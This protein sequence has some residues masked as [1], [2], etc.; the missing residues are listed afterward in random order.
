[1]NDKFATI[2][3]S[4][5]PVLIDFFATW[6]G[7]CQML[8]PILK[9]VKESL[10][11]IDATRVGMAPLDDVSNVEKEWLHPGQAVVDTV[12]HPL[13]TK[14]LKLAKEAGATKFSKTMDKKC[15]AFCLS[16]GLRALIAS[17]ASFASF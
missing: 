11:I 15:S 13:E 6:C 16:C 9:E 7:P 5:K 1:M 4:E 17:R 14:L 10:V 2:I 12:Y 8:G 3:N